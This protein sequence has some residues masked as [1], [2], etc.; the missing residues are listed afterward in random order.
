MPR[1]SELDEEFV[2]PYRN[3]CPYLE[4][5]PAQWVWDRHQKCDGL[6][7]QYEYQLKELNQQLDQAEGRNQELERQ[8]QQ[9]KAQL[10]ALHRR[11]FK[12]RKVPAAP[13]PECSWAQ[14]K[15]RGAPVGHPHWQRPKPKHIDQVVSVP[16]PQSCPRCHGADL[17]PVK[18]LHEHV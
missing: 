15:K 6:E 10:H 5:L 18:E 17:Q 9:L 1:F 13:T 11:Q 4:G 3:G 7:C 2:C 8:N 12:G 16:A 14:R